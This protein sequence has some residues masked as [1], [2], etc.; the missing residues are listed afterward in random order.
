[1]PLWGWEKTV[2]FITFLFLSRRLYIS[3]NLTCVLYIYNCSIISPIV[4]KKFKAETEIYSWFWTGNWNQEIFMNHEKCQYWRINPVIFEKKLQTLRL[5]SRFIYLK[6][7]IYLFLS[8]I[9]EAF[10]A[11]ENVLSVKTTRKKV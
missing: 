9:S 1:M 6:I 2:T 10:Y 11:I 4:W 5:K 7:F 8:T 3:L